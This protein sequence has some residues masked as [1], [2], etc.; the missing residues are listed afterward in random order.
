MHLL[1]SWMLLQHVHV[2]A[3]DH[4]YLTWGEALV[5][6]IRQDSMPDARG[7]MTLIITYDRTARR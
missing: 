7:H 3:C 4:E 1:P 6:L 5:I 2:L